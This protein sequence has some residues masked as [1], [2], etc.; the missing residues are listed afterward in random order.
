M[1]S[2]KKL[3]KPIF[4]AI[5]A[6]GIGLPHHEYETELMVAGIKP[7]IIISPEDVTPE[8]Q[9]AIDK[10]L[11]VHIEGH[12]GIKTSRIYCHNDEI[13]TAK[14]A[15][16]ILERA[17]GN[18]EIPTA[19]E[20]SFLED[21]FDKPIQKNPPI[22]SSLKWHERSN[23][24]LTAVLN[25]KITTE[26]H[27][28]L[29]GELR[30]LSPIDYLPAHMNA[31]PLESALAEGKISAVD[32]KQKILVQVFAQANHIEDGKELYARY[33]LDRHDYP[34]LSDDEEEKR[35]GRLLG[36][37]E[38]DVAWFTGEKYQSPLLRI[39]MH[40]TAP[41]RRWARKELMMMDANP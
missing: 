22:P 35:I 36:Y 15:A 33:Y 29:G 13:E 23:A 1:S 34:E 2:L 6:P 39:L 10:G 21:F 14:D 31:H 5:A 27:S 37:S 25:H 9:N 16:K 26:M 18:N 11:I 28:M 12:Q 41:I 24:H 40:E 30:A 4:A 32:V 19:D 17:F 38:N 20:M 8:M 3:L 7:V